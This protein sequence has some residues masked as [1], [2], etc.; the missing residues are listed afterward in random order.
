MIELEKVK[1]IIWDL[2]DTFWN[3]TLSEGGVKKC[4]NVDLVLSLTDCGIINA[5]CSKND[6]DLAENELE[7]LGVKDLFVFNSID[8]TPKGPRIKKMI[9]DMGLRP[10]NVL[11]ID[12]NTVNLNEAK[13][14]SPELMIAQPD[15]IE[16]IREFVNNSEKKDKS[17]KRLNQYKVL[18]Q[19]QQSRKDFSDNLSFLYS[20]HTKVEIHKNCFDE[21][22]RIH[23]LILRTN[24]LNYTK[25][26]INKD[27]LKSIIEDKNVD[28]GYV[29]VNDS[30][31]DYGIVGF[32][33]LAGRRLEHFLFSCRAIGQGVEQWVYANL[34]YPEL[35]V[36]G[37]VI[38]AVTNDPAP[39][40]INKVEETGMLEANTEIHTTGK[41]LIKGPCD[42]GILV[43][44]LNI[45]N[46]FCEFTYQGESNN[47]IEHYN[48]S[49]NFLTFPF[50]S[51]PVRSQ[52]LN[53]CIFN[54]EK[55][56][57]TVMY[58]E[59]VKLIILS[60]QTDPNLGVYKNRNTG[61][62]IAF[63]EY[64]YPLTDPSNWD[65]YVKKEFCTYD[66]DFTKEWLEAFSEKYEYIGRITP[67][68]YVENIK[69]LLNKINKNA[70][71]CLLLGSET[72]Y[73]A[74]RQ[75]AYEKREEYYKEANRL[76]RELAK[77]EPRLRLV[78]F[79]DFIHS[80]DDFLDNINHYKRHVYYKAAKEVR[81]I[82]S[83][84]TDVKPQ[85]I[86]RFKLML[87][88][89]ASTF[90]YSRFRNNPI[91]RISRGIYHKLRD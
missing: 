53:D 59:D 84:V 26:R 52:L 60:T 6:R 33:A 57:D 45:P 50:L 86:S 71:L 47:S 89:I 91:F 74:N 72:P 18:E 77:N 75:V 61:H 69:H 55:M 56:F 27:E 7:Q 39:D 88:E 67:S 65:G 82:I 40:W 22:D 78:C 10:I 64:C 54:D 19:K 46:A 79:G 12:D 34:D 83:D 1:L 68:E 48:H 38:N 44:Y 80:Q 76:L 58:D 3:G 62:L 15:L 31:G 5:I 63:A 42:L 2:D 21:L 66:N 29:T 17:H 23:E 11:F 41:I 43:S 35:D 8:W 13:F 20:T 51:E 49:V 4:N 36:V 14:Y 90:R 16:E 70:T 28:C 37:T 9:E 24:Q 25:K 30:F 73:N 87:D 81:Q 32:Y 85:Q